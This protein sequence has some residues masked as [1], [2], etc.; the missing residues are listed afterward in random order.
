MSARPGA[1]ALRARLRFYAITPD[2]WTLPGEYAE[3]V[4]RALELGVT[5]VQFR[6]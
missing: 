2:A 1:D 4:T 5:C 3:R 6:D